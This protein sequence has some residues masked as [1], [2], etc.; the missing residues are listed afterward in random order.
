MYETDMG[1]FKRKTITY[2]NRF[3]EQETRVDVI[4]KMKEI[5]DWV[6]CYVT[7]EK[8]PTEEIDTLRLMLLQKLK[9]IK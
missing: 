9:D 5:K 8:V 4:L 1:D 2:L 3:L 6:I 7:P